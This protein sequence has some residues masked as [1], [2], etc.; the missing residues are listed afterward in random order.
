MKGLY[1]EGNDP[2]QGEKWVIQGKG[3]KEGE[4]R[5]ETKAI[6]GRAGGQGAGW[7]WKAGCVRTMQ[8]V[9]RFDGNVE[10]SSSASL[11]N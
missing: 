5:E 8:E 1:A 10:V 6:E 2:A 7:G 4:E 11:V 3:E 9:R